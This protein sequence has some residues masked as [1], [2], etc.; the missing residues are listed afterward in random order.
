MSRRPPADPLHRGTLAFKQHGTA[1][2]L[3]V[4]EGVFSAAAVDAGTRHL[5]RWLAADRYE[6]VGTVLDLGCGYGPLGLWLAA[7]HPGTRVLAVDRDARA[8]AATA[9]GAAR[10]GLSG[11]VEVRGSLGY[12]DVAPDERFDLVVSNIPAKVGPAALRHLLLGASRH[13]TDDGLA[14]VVVVDRLAGEV[15]EVLDAPSV[16]VLDRRPSKGYTAFEYRFDTGEPIADTG[17]FDAGAYRRAQASFELG[18]LRW[19]AEA[20][21][22]LPEFDSIGHGTHAALELLT[23]RGA[24]RPTAAPLAV[25]GVGQG[26]VPVALRV[27]GGAG[28]VRLVDRDLL[29]L[30]TAARNLPGDAPAILHA[31]A[32]TP[33]ALD[34]AELVVVDLPERE[35]VAVTAAVLGSA[36]AGAAVGDVVVHGRSADLSRV[37]ELLGRHG[38][39]VEVAARTRVGQHAAAR[40]RVHRTRATPPS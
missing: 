23:G 40:G 33:E 3:D 22:S 6:G 24:A 28:D 12:D 31:P 37:L 7:A 17:G 19:G 1:V 16:E 10:N 32:P 13:L 25:V 34:G 15:D 5:L 35:P 9:A 36:L 38:A 26:H 30:R 18:E 14:A 20:S 39:R 27:A 8:L 2:E 4:F 21:F 11:R 29:A